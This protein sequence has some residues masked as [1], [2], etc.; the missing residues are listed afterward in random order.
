M[1]VFRIM[2]NTNY[3]VMSNY[4]LRDTR[5]SLKAV[6]LLSKM[7]SLADEWNYTNRGLSKICKEGVDAVGSAL[8]ELESAG[9]LERRQ[10][11]SES[12]KI[13][14]TEYIIYEIPQDGSVDKDKLDSQKSAKK[15]SEN[16]NKALTDNKS[17]TYT[18]AVTE[19]EHDSVEPHTPY[20]GSPY[21]LSPYTGIP[22]MVV[23]DT[24][25]TAQLN[26][27]ISITSGSNINPSSCGEMDRMDYQ[28]AASLIRDNIEYD[29]LIGRF[30]KSK[31]NL[32][33]EIAA[34][35]LC[36][37]SDY[38]SVG[39]QKYPYDIAK[40]RMLQLDCECVTYVFDCLSEVNST[41][42][43][44]KPYLTKAL[45]DAPITMDCDITEKVRRAM[46]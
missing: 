1:P 23:P 32:V 2:K 36:S 44:I 5:L 43:C 18:A 9:Y 35:I 7:L 14:D 4:H 13:Q 25:S 17:D 12:G 39:Q 20:T 42:R 37:T 33:V 19:P 30:P 22:D 26:K 24:E 21:T 45:I 28:T 8:R 41:I 6:G 16:R 46:Y 11:R 38:I 31:V 40:S 27:D 34:E 15:R 10:L 29:I 3:T